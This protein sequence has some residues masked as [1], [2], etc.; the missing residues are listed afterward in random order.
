V[1]QAVNNAEDDLKLFLFVQKT[2]AIGERKFIDKRI[3]KSV[4]RS[5]L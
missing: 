3:C 1:Y 2:G 5:L 4:N